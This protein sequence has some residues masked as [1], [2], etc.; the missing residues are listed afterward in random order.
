MGIISTIRTTIKVNEI[1]LIEI[2]DRSPLG[3]ISR[4]EISSEIIVDGSF[5]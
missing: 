3:P 4:N 2:I 1:I 5:P